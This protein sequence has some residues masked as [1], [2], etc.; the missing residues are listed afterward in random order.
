M[1]VNA[2][3]PGKDVNILHCAA[4]SSNEENVLIDILNLPKFDPTFGI[5][6][7]LGRPENSL[8]HICA[9]MGWA[10]ASR[11]LLQHGANP[12]QPNKEGFSAFHL[13]I[14][15]MHENVVRAFL[16]WGC[17]P[18]QECPDIFPSIQVSWNI[19]TG[20]LFYI[21]VNRSDCYLENVFS[22]GKPY[23]LLSV[24]LEAKKASPSSST[25][26]EWSYRYRKCWFHDRT[27]P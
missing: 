8:L 26:H 13:A 2:I 25:F 14:I 20:N 3:V 21:F 5:N 1:Q 22:Y 18:Y 11:R 17:S 12:A 27:A 7:K 16:E 4:F 6:K 10:E 19:Q 24:V 15:K 23:F 9:R